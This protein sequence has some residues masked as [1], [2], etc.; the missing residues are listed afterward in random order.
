MNEANISFK[1]LSSNEGFARMCVAAFVSEL[2]PTVSEINDIKTAVSEAVTNCIIHG[3]SDSKG[4][5][6]IN[7]KIKE[8]TLF[9]EIKDEGIGIADIDKAT[10]PLY[11]S[12]PEQE[13]SGLGFTVMQSFM[14][15]MDVISYEG[16][17]TTIRLSKNITG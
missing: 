7:L 11:T 5:I 17:G 6:Y 13:R 8:K 16:K 15:S 4:I 1:A 2:S 10:Q 14:D 3:Y 9:I 12:K